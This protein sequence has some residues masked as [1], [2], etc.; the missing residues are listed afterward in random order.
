MPPRQHT[1]A[2]RYPVGPVH[3]YSLECNGELILIDTGAPTEESKEYL[4]AN[5]DLNRL[6]YV[7]ITHCHIDH[8]GLAA[9]LEREYD[10][11][12]Y[13]PYRDSLKITRHD[14]R[15]DGQSALLGEIG[16][17]R[18]FTEAF[19]TD[20]DGEVV[21]PEVPRHFKTVED[22]LPAE[23]GIQILSCPGHSQSDLVY[24]GADWAVTGD[25]MLRNIFQSPLLD[26]DLLTGQRFNNYYAYCDTIVKLA[27]LRDKQILPGH[28]EYIVGIDDNIRFY[29]G[30][31][32]E[33]A[34]RNRSFPPEL[35]VSQVVER[36]FGA[37]REQP[38]LKYLKAS[39]IV[40]IRDFLAEPQ[41]LEKSL[42]EIGLFPQL[43]D[44]F[45][46]ATKGLDFDLRAK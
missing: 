45:E 31:L 8:Y 46:L 36:L 6:K 28:R 17:N 18:E 14:E 11:T 23:L 1:I 37:N 10:A 29:T 30:K 24:V 13:L 25:T 22:S 12:I 42:K 19:R 2:T 27:T 15:L 38:F 41:R 4:R 5:L 20:M 16:F 32:L 34:R 44:R 21:F 7:L 35:T 9:W 43:A 3:C 26:I 33:R 40:F 39:E